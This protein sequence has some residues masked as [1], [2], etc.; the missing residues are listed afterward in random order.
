MWDCRRGIRIWWSLLLDLSASNSFLAAHAGDTN[1]NPPLF[2]DSKL[3]SCCTSQQNRKFQVSSATYSNTFC[4]QPEQTQTHTHS[5]TVCTYRVYR[6]MLSPTPV[7]PKANHI[8]SFS[9]MRTRGTPR[10]LVKCGECRSDHTFLPSLLFDFQFS[11][12]WQNLL[13]ARQRFWLW[14]FIICVYFESG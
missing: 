12:N 5:H 2:A 3:G 4:S 11:K 6:K 14:Y 1:F 7:T 10:Q 9:T 13:K 8:L